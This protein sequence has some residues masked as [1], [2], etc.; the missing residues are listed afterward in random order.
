MNSNNSNNIENIFNFFQNNDFNLDEESDPDLNY[1][2]EINLPEFVCTYF[3]PNKI[4]NFLG[5]DNKS[6]YF[7][8]MHVNIRSLK[9]NFENF[10]NLISE[11]N[12]YF[13][14]IC[15][16]ETW[17][18]KQDFELN[19]NL[20]LPGFKEIFLERNNNKRGG[21]VLFYL[22]ENIFYTIRSD[23]SVSDTDQEIL[24]IELINKNSKNI[25]I[26]C[27]YRP[28]TGRTENLSKY[29]KNCLIEK[30]RQEKK[31]IYIVGDFNLDCFEYSKN[32]NIK[33]FYNNLFN[34]GTIPI[35]N[36]PT[37]VTT[38]SSSL[39]D[40][41]LTTDYFN[42][43]LKKGIIKT[44]VSDH[45]PIFFSIKSD[46]RINKGGRVMIKK[47]VFNNNNL[48]SFKNQFLYEDWSHISFNDNINVIYDTF[49]RTFFKIY[50]TNFPVCEILCKT[51]DILSPWITKGL[52]KSSKIKK[53]QKLY[54][55]YIKTKSEK[56]KQ[57]YKNY[58]NLF[59]KLRKNAKKNYYSKLLTQH[60]DN[61]KRV[62]GIMKEI[63]GK[64]K[65]IP[66]SLPHTIK[67]ENKIINDTN[68]IAT[69]FNHFFSTI[70]KNLSEKI[71][72][73]N[74]KLI[75][76]LETSNYLQS[77]SLTF[78]EFNI[79]F[80]S[81]K[82][83][84]SVG[85]D[86]INGNVVIDSYDVMKDILYKIFNASIEQG[87]FPDSLKIAKVIP[88]FK[89][90][91]PTNI[92]NYRPISV[93]PVF[94]KI[95]EKIMHNRVY[96]YLI[97]NK[98]LYENQFGFKKNNSTE[99]AILQL[100]RYINESF[101]KL[102]FTLGV[103]IDLSKAFDTVDHSILLKK[104]ECYGIT[105]KTLCWFKSYLSNRKQFVF[106]KDSLSKTIM[107]ITH[108]V[109]QGSILGPLLFIVYI[110]DLCKAS[111]LKTIIFADDTNLFL[112]HENINILFS[113][114]NNELK[115]ISFWFK[116]NRLS[117][118]I[119]KTKW[120]IFYPNNKKQI[121]PIIMP[122]LYIDNTILKREKITK[123]LGIFIDENLSWRPHINN[124]SNKVAKS[125]GILYKSRDILNKKQLTELYYS[126]IHCHLNYANIVWGSTHKT[127]LKSLYQHQKHA[128]RVINF[129]SRFS[130]SKPLLK[131]MNALNIYQLNVFNVLCFMFKCKEL[132]SPDVFTNLYK[133]K[134]LNKYNLRCNNILEKPIFKNKHD[135]FCISYRGPSLWNTIALPNLPLTS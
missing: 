35:I 130:N 42:K 105:G 122:D 53:N 57:N 39:I 115:K 47:R 11:T 123:F 90:G 72:L 107:N 108:G 106:N 99:H 54:V 116:K 100:T 128:A 83:N 78:E 134:P 18:S 30:T 80:K 1:F 74:Y 98:L 133:I 124:I 65:I 8:V 119:D 27:C 52:K 51:K 46:Y 121:L 49:I 28:P 117:L 40:N 9:K 22:K 59:E 110:N 44:D 113:N 120:T 21:G 69:K 87:S 71:P 3:E 118:N 2:N 15:I 135:Q 34:I 66:T 97:N 101:K 129:K 58:K 82:R 88:I 92:T 132:M 95:L 16:T 111:N 64:Q 60:K 104:L 32:Q 31:Y 89:T 127:K 41:I 13:N 68:E 103:F 61:L 77:P 14:V 29:L 79:A 70:G 56:H 81:L 48:K 125:I 102:K 36:R 76:N 85:P 96:T 19:T 91:D 24:T 93:L 75:D 114:M 63:T 25:I 50:D 5:V 17:C 73:T 126:F 33:H 20:L 4:S 37:R 7:N 12:N 86:E 94:S 67:V 62:W 23:M 112:S 45:F 10:I 109:P 55:K 26:S 131:E 38:H 84:K 6:D 43:S